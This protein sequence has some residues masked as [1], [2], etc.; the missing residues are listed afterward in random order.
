MLEGQSPVDQKEFDDLFNKFEL[1]KR[2][3]L[4]YGDL[5][6]PFFRNYLK[7]HKIKGWE[8]LKFYNFKKDIISSSFSGGKITKDN[9]CRVYKISG[10]KNIY[11][12][13]R[14]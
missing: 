13:N 9:L 1:G 3:I 5:D 12:K 6:E 14:T 7:R 4:H 10:I 2:V 8:N 11:I